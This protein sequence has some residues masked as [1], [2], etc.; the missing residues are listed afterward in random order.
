[1]E[2]GRENS[3]LLSGE[4]RHIQN[5]SNSHTMSG[6]R[7]DTQEHCEC[8]TPETKSK[9]YKNKEAQTKLVIAAL[10]ALT[11]AIAEAVG[12]YLSSS[13]A[14]L[15]DAAH[16]LSDFSG[17]LVSLLSLWISRKRATK[18]MSFGFHRAEVM[19]AVISVLIIWLVTGI[20]VYEGIQRVIYQDFEIDA[21]IMLIISTA[22]LYVN[23][24]MAMI[25]Q[26]HVHHM[27]GLHKHHS[28][29]EEHDHEHAHD[30]HG[31]GDGHGH[32]H[33]IEH[34]HDNGD[35]CN[36]D[37]EHL[38]GVH[39]QNSKRFKLKKA[40]KWTKS[41]LKHSHSHDHNEN[42]NLRAALIHCIGDIVQSIG[43]I[44]AAYI[45]RFKPEWKIVDPICTFFFSILVLFTTLNIMK[46]AIHVLMEGTPK[47]INFLAVKK[48]LIAIEG[49]EQ[50]HTL[51]IWSIS[52]TR[53]ALAGHIVIRPQYDSQE[54][55]KKAFQLARTKYGI[56]QCTLQI[57]TYDEV[58]DTCRG[59]QSEAETVPSGKK[60]I[61]RLLIC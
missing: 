51:N 3:S 47:N 56:D 11:F 58:M 53:T 6:R 40:V 35:N 34:E 49:V 44:I 4:A 41:K 36:C 39:V 16:M 45:I 46:D 60:G 33:E 48:D 59:C 7:A 17:I 50:A 57:E 5:Y 22:G 10:L 32:G 28:H 15:S 8:H 2:D 18:S 23:V 42:I 43:V 25:L 13:L 30:E 12:G 24:F 54:I 1:M 38:T 52:S 14:V 27:E 37:G 31:H 61:F 29:D 20:L 21:D 55:L 19:G 9:N 26:T